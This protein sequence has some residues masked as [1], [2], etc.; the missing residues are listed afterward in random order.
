MF[1]YFQ[2]HFIIFSGGQNCSLRE[3]RVGFQVTLLL[4]GK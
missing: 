2:G 3:K 1:Q 4:K